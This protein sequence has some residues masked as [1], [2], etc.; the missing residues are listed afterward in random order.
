[1]TL[2]LS[3]VKEKN[4]TN[5][6]KHKENI[7]KKT[8]YMK[9]R[10]I[11]RAVFLLTALFLLMVSSAFA[12]QPIPVIGIYDGN[13]GTEKI[14]F[15]ADGADYGVLKGIF[16]LNRGKAVEETHSFTLR[17]SGGKLMFQSD[18]YVGCLKGSVDT[19]T[20]KGKISLYNK[21]KR[22]LFWYQKEE[23]NMVK[24]PETTFSASK[25]YQEE[26]FPE[27]NVT[28]NIVYGK[29]VGY[30][31]ESPYTDEPY[32]EVLA[33]G[34]VKLF[35]NTDSLDL[36][37]DLYQ[38][39]GDTL[40]KRPLI[41]FIHGGAFYVGSKQC[42]TAKL[43]STHLAKSGFVVASIDYRM[44]F[45]PSAGNVERSGYKAVQDA[46][47]ALRYLSHFSA[48]FKID[49]SQVYVAGTSA[50]G[51]ASLNLAFLD[52]DERPESVLEENLG[53][54]ESSGNSFTDPFQIK[55]VGNMWGAISDI[56]MIDAN[57]NI[58][59]LSIHGTADDIVPFGYNYP[60]EKAFLMN[61]LFMN[62]MYGSQPIHDRLNKFGI[63]NKLVALEGLKHELNVDKFKNTNQFM[64]TLSFDLSQ[65]LYSETAPD[66][67]F[68]TK[69]LNV[70]SNAQMNPFYSEIKNGEF[71]ATLITGGVK[72]N[73]DPTGLN[74]IWFK[75]NYN[76]Q[77]TLV[78]KNRFDAWSVKTY[79]VIIAGN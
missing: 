76:R 38:P 2:C 79:T 3:G 43:L 37:L 72:S 26:L 13:I 47:A 41:L 52:N 40:S 16:V 6:L 19:T 53:K 11:I 45:K 1:V 56:N 21:R 57:E 77:I 32:V 60:F 65:F 27:I 59:V 20:F 12:V 50:G 22:F 34:M 39:V 4:A 68:P 18:L 78:A 8:N 71:V 63:R 49:P 62:K 66:I 35:K 7:K 46:H 75:N 28:E 70:S 42:T 36:K 25:R 73:S 61:R 29:A 44:G 14:I 64:D 10:L 55:G 17:H 33:K 9:L 5:S 15:I 74:V 48:E 54:I 69:Q 58:P 24:R 30:W 67:F 31:T 51:I 23:F